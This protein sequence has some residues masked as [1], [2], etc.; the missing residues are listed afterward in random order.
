M[1]GLKGLGVRYKGLEYIKYGNLW[2]AFRDRLPVKVL[3][4]SVF[5]GELHGRLRH[6]LSPRGHFDRNKNT[7]RHYTTKAY[8][9][10]KASEMFRKTGT[11]TRAYKCVY[12]D[13]YHIG[14]ERSN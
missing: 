4:T 6:L 10:K 12:C 7:K 9:E 8:A 13:Y 1:L 14:R 2:R 3:L 11:P 5:R